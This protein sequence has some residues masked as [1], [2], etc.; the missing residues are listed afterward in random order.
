MVNNKQA[1]KIIRFNTDYQKNMCFRSFA[2]L[3]QEHLVKKNC[4]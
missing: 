4:N 1:V 2:V 3:A